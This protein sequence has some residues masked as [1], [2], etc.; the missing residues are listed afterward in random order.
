M[1][2]TEQPWSEVVR[3]AVA[4]LD[5][6]L[7]ERVRLEAALLANTQQFQALDSGHHATIQRLLTERTTLQR[8]IRDQSD[9]RRIAEIEREIIRMEDARYGPDA[10]SP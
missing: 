9:A 6:L 4:Q 2:N 8:R 7:A 10:P 5:A 3:Q 1:K